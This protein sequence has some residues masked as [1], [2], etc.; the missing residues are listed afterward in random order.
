M[1]LAGEKSFVFFSRRS[2]RE[3][4]SATTFFRLSCS[5]ARTWHRAVEILA[6]TSSSCTA[7]SWR[8]TVLH[9]PIRGWHS[10]ARKKKKPEGSRRFSRQFEKTNS[11]EFLYAAAAQKIVLR[12]STREV[13]VF[14][15][16]S[17]AR[18]FWYAGSF[19]EMCCYSGGRVS[20]KKSPSG[21]IPQQFV[22]CWFSFYTSIMSFF[23]AVLCFK[24][25]DALLDLLWFVHR[26]AQEFRVIFV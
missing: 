26:S 6:R 14:L 17:V 18:R 15:F 24:I 1:A 7:D 4:S 5:R 13:S 20:Q 9:A 12:G 21:L 25:R 8:K 23:T 11:G 19:R 3:G 16:F 10:R 2:I 22:L